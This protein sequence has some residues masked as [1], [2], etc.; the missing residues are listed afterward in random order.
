[1][2]GCFRLIL[3][4]MVALSHF[5]CQFAG[6]NP[7]QWAVVCFYVLSGLLMER[8]YKKITEAGNPGS[9]FYVDRLLRIFPMYLVVLVL[10]VILTPIS[11]AAFA[12][13]ALLLPLDYTSFFKCPIVIGPAWSLA[14]EFHFYLLV[15]LL[16][17]CSDRQIKGLFLCSLFIFTISP[18]LPYSTFWAYSGLPGI[19]FTFLTGILI[20]RKATGFLKGV[21]IIMFCLLICFLLTKLE[22]LKLPTGININVCVGYMIAMAAV[23]ILERLP[24]NRVWDKKAGLIAF[25]LFLCHEI[26][27]A[28]IE[29]KFDMHNILIRVLGAMLFAGLL[30]MAIEMPVD[31][32]RYG[33]RR[34]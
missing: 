23:P 33:L 3:A 6:F 2:F 29:T 5:G 10:G 18:F 26:V 4:L 24:N 25:P 19:I 28:F 34:R 11:H 32:F 12:A 15:P 13:N 31:R 16:C 30:V 9:L 14:C 17:V 1:M 27:S 7:G 20:N 8:Q 21:S 22:K